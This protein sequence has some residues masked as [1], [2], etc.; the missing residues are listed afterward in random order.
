MS[1]DEVSN[2][3]TDFLSSV[4]WLSLG[5]VIGTISLENIGTCL[6]FFLP[7]SIKAFLLGDGSGEDMAES[8]RQ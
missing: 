2:V 3:E 6:F 1:C 4:N 8:S 7:S 5:T